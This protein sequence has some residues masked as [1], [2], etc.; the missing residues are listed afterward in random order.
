MKNRI[1]ETCAT[2]KYTDWI[3]PLLSLIIIADVANAKG[4]NFFFFKFIYLKIE[5]VENK[6]IYAVTFLFIA[7]II[8]KKSF[9]LVPLLGIKVAL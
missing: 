1:V 6:H 5:N 8:K 4:E 2:F 7:R 3:Y 9:F